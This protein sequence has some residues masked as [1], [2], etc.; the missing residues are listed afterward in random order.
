MLLR[1]EDTQRQAA[2]GVL[3]REL[4]AKV[5]PELKEPAEDSLV[6]PEISDIA[7]LPDAI[8][9]CRRHGKAYLIRRQIATATHCTL[10]KVG[11]FCRGV[12]QRSYFID[13]ESGTL[14][15]LASERFAN[16]L[17]TATGLNRTETE[18]AFVLEHLK[19][20]ASNLPERPIR[21][22]SHFDS[23]TETFYLHGG[24]KEIFTA[25]ALGPSIYKTN[26][27]GEIF[28]TPE[29]VEAFTPDYSANG[30]ALKWFLDLPSFAE[31]EAGLTREDQ[32]LLLL[33]VLVFLLFTQEIKPIIVAIGPKGSGKTT[34]MRGLLILFLGTKQKPT[35]ISVDR[36]L[37][38]IVILFAHN[39]IAVIDNLDS[40]VKG[41]EDLFA[42]HVTGAEF[43]R[44]ALYTN[45]TQHVIQLF[46]KI[47][48]ITS[49]TP[50]FAR[51]DV[52]ERIIP[53]HFKRPENGIIGE[54]V[55]YSNVFEKRNAIMGDLLMLVSQV[56]KNL[57][58]ESPR[59]NLRMADFAEFGW[60][61]H[62]RQNDGQWT[63]PEWE[64]LLNKL[65][66]AQDRFVSADNALIEVLEELLDNG[67]PILDMPVSELFKKCRGVAEDRHLG[68]PKT[69]IRFGQALSEMGSTIQTELNAKFVDRRGHAG[70]RFITLTA[71][72]TRVRVPSKLDR[73][74][75]R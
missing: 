65:A 56:I 28:V 9:R 20:Q 70:K 46:A 11:S 17:A 31:N 36:P 19:V 8:T 41:V 42:V 2:T 29:G 22:L 67:P 13:K 45:D 75:R 25:D 53:L 48:G 73:V 3:V 18:F 50:R 59:L 69:A 23:K 16:L 37:D 1:D 35:S 54:T 32:K 6:V 10:Q 71:N 62:A 68:I 33:T 61:M 15:D 39:S 72:E 52:A 60:K 14:Y 57:K 43:K 63:S 40:F 27:D 51:P 64:A 26:G 24:G 7:Q 74:F 38:D 30:E 5:T 21:A 66:G 49:R 44:R 4:L 58:I 55:I 34:L 12:G 47:V